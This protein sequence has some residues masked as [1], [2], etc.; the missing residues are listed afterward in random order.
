MHYLEDNIKIIQNL[1]ISYS[2]NS[3][4]IKINVKTEKIFVIIA[5]PLRPSI[6]L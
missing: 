2:F 4:D 5:R 1:K 3:Y 6:I